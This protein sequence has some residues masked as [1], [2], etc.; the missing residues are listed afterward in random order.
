MAGWKFA[1]KTDLEFPLG[2][3]FERRN[4][5]RAGSLISPDGQGKP[6]AALLTGYKPKAH[7]GRGK[8]EEE[9][10]ARGAAPPVLH[11]R[12][13]FRHPAGEWPLSTYRLDSLRRE[14][15]SVTL[16]VFS[17]FSTLI[18]AVYSCINCWR[19]GPL[20]TQ[21]TIHSVGTFDIRPITSR[22]VV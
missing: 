5:W 22:N 19:E 17:R 12:H 16:G 1:P 15:V 18:G 10:S 11:G 2:D 9:R 14:S 8:G 4:A 6:R 3:I 21:I 20:C 13:L 7:T